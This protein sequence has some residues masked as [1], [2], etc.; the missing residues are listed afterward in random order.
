MR[1]ANSISYS[2]SQYHLVCPQNQISQLFPGFIIFCFLIA[3]P[4]LYETPFSDYATL[5]VVFLL[6][7]LAIFGQSYGNIH[8]KDKKL[9]YLFCFAIVFLVFLFPLGNSWLQSAVRI[10]QYAGCFFAFLFGSKIQITDRAKN[11]SRFLI[12]LFVV[13]SLFFWII[14][15]M[16]KTNYSFYFANPNT[17]S[18]VL[19]VDFGFLWAMNNKRMHNY[20]FIVG[21]TFLSYLTG[22]RSSLIA[23]VVFI[24]FYV[25][26]I[27]LYKKK[28][29]LRFFPKFLLVTI[30]ALLSLFIFFYPTM[31]DSPFGQELQNYSLSKFG[32]LFF[33]GRNVIWKNLLDAISQK[34]LF[35]YGLDAT[36]RLIY[37]TEFSSHNLYLQIMLQVGIVGFVVLMAPLLFIS[38]RLACI[39]SKLSIVFFCFLILILIHECFEVTFT[40]NMIIS[41]LPMWFLLGVGF[42]E[43]RMNNYNGQKI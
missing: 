25:L 4:L 27:L 8:Y 43:N 5:L 36:P 14:T 13:T 34:P 26:L 30:V 19:L 11:I 32:K 40:Q 2:T 31:L 21:I 24:V 22:C 6:C 7:L 15:G 29:E 38:L 39:K 33:S 1:R 35:G 17:Y 37:E 3:L 20:L 12:Y 41:G 23:I 42:H 10:I 16:P 28:G 9:I 18:A